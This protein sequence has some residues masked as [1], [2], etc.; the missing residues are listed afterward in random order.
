MEAL[1]KLLQA[2]TAIDKNK[3]INTSIRKNKDEVIILNTESQLFF[4][5]IDSTG[6]KLES[7]GG[8]YSA[9]T[10]N[11]KSIKGQ[12]TNRVTLKDTG[13]FYDTFTVSA[14][15]KDDSFTINANTIKDEDDLTD[16][17]GEDIIGLT[18]ESIEELNEIIKPDIIDVFKEE[19]R[20]I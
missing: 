11:I 2:V 5:G 18:D 6:T 8:G 15:D 13:E 9:F 1:T 16:R 14:K 4:K 7:I 12:P 20:A 10:K 3:I 19:I 17:W